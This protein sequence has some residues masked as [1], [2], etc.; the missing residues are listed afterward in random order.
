GRRHERVY[1]RLR[2]AVAPVRDPVIVA[3][4]KVGAHIPE[5]R[6]WVPAFAGTTL[7]EWRPAMPRTLKRGLSA[8]AV[9]AADAK[10]R[11]TVESILADVKARGD[12]AIRELSK[13]FDNWEPASFR[14]SPQEIERAISQVSK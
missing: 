3:P 11:A 4:A 6:L 14:L 8:D 13:K 7:N 10:V 2:R 5:L 9:E 12:A 1:A